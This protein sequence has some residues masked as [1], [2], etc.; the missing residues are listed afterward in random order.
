MSVDYESIPTDPYSSS[1]MIIYMNVDYGRW[2]ALKAP[3]LYGD[4]KEEVPFLER[5]A[6]RVGSQISR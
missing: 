6:R 2:R 3:F 5:L 4:L 1:L